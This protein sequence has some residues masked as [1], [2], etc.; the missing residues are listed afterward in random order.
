MMVLASSDR[1]REA[2]SARAPSSKAAY[3]N[4]NQKI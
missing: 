1:D 2:M 3:G 4:V